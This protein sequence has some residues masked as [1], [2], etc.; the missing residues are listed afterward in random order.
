MNSAGAVLNESQA[1][2]QRI[3]IAGIVQNGA[4]VDARIQINI[5]AAVN[6]DLNYR[7][8][9]I[10]T[11]VEL[12]LVAVVE[13]QVERAAAIDCHHWSRER[14]FGTDV[15]IHDGPHMI[16]DIR[17]ADPIPLKDR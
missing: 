5:G 12:E 16:G 4:V 13:L 17:L 1:S 15:T 9:V 2:L 11:G 8:V 14:L 3:H 6:A 7:T 10:T